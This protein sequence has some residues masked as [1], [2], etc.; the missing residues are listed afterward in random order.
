MVKKAFDL[1]VIEKILRSI[2]LRYDYVVC[3]IEESHNLDFMIV[4]EVQSSLLV[5]EQQMNDHNSHEKLHKIRQALVVVGEEMFFKVELHEEEVEVKEGNNTVLYY[6]HEFGHF[7]SECPKKSQDSRTNYVE[8]GEEAVLLMA[9]LLTNF[10]SIDSSFS[11]EVKLRNNYVLKVVGKGIVKLLINEVMHLVNDV[12][13][14]H[15]KKGATV[16]FC[17]NASIIKLS[18]NP[19]L[20]ERSKYIDVRFYFLRDLCMIIREQLVD[21]MIKPLKVESFQHL[22]NALDMLKKPKINCC[23][24]HII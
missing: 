7:Q 23:K 14:V 12:F 5:H 19:I 3:T 10:S 2:T 16:M 6:C 15:C 1:S 20:Q 24:E 8:G 4:D 22:R 17:D 13:Y 11:D 18:K 9:Q 21:I